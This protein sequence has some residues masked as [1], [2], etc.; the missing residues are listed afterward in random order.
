[1]YTVC[2]LVQFQLN[3]YDYVYYIF[4]SN[5]QKGLYLHEIAHA[6]GVV[7]EHQRPIRDNY[8]SIIYANVEPSM[9]IWFQK[10][11]PAAINSYDVD[12]ELSSVI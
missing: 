9:K 1:M 11:N 5:S 4:L 8:I 10:Y 3:I 6:L 7:H 12:Y 2:Y